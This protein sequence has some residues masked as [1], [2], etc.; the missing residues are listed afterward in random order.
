MNSPK[1][2]QKSGRKSKYGE[3]TT[4][5]RIPTS[6]VPLVAE[7]LQRREVLEH[8]WNISYLPPVA[9]HLVDAITELMVAPNI[10]MLACVTEQLGSS[11]NV[12]SAIADLEQFIAMIRGE[13]RSIASELITRSLDRA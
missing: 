4:I 12:A 8:Q 10:S 9:Q 3:S 11:P 2:A 7:M 6:M 13:S 1:Q 5:M